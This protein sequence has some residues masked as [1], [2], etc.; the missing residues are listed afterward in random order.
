[1]ESLFIYTLLAI[2]LLLH[3]YNWATFHYSC[4]ENFAISSS[5][6][7]RI[8]DY[9]KNQGNIVSIINIYNNRDTISTDDFNN[10]NIIQTQHTFK[11]TPAPIWKK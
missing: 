9:K 6:Q 2:L 3:V 11:S 1:M 5:D 8:D 4:V 7:Q 10:T